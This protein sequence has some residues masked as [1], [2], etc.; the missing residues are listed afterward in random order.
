MIE[1]QGS[2]ISEPYWISEGSLAPQTTRG[3]QPE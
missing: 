3:L 2:E 1:A